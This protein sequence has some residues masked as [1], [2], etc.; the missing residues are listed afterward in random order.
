MADSRKIL[1]GPPQNRCFGWNFLQNQVVP[2]LPRKALGRRGNLGWA[3]N[4]MEK[5]TDIRDIWIDA[6]NPLCTLYVSTGIVSFCCILHNVLIACVHFI[7]A[8][9]DAR[10]QCLWDDRAPEYVVSRPNKQ[11]N[12][13]TVPDPNVMPTLRGENHEL[14]L[15]PWLNLTIGR[16]Q[17]SFVPD[18]ILFSMAQREASH[19]RD[20]SRVLPQGSWVRV[21]CCTSYGFL[22]N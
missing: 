15:L 10:E 17:F 2:L 1:A 7:E 14:Y 22:L 11:T 5:N 6:H 21:L 9:L 19:F 8:L 18:W 3:K 12:K 4:P 13:N 20:P 16:I